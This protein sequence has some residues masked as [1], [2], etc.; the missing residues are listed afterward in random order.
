MSCHLHVGLDVDSL[1]VASSLAAKRLA[2]R[3]PVAPRKLGLAEV[4]EARKHERVVDRHEL[5]LLVELQRRRVR[6][7][8]EDVALV[9]IA[10][11]ESQIEK[12]HALAC[13][14]AKLAAVEAV[15]A[16]VA[17]RRHKLLDRARLLVQP[18]A[19]GCAQQQCVDSRPGYPRKAVV[20][21]VGHQ[22]ARRAV[23]RPEPL[24]HGVLRA[25]QPA[26]VV[27]ASGLLVRRFEHRY[28]WRRRCASRPLL[29]HRL[30]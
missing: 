26:W 27:E 18:R 30:I 25:M 8:H 19:G 23:A 9:P 11:E 14:R 6:K 22:L 7:A 20:K 29:R 12:R 15:L 4:A 13:T 10:V 28:G 3:E 16:R 17:L 5:Q 24:T 2:R 21:I 1:D